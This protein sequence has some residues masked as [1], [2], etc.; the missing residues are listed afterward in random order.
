MNMLTLDYIKT[1]LPTRPDNSHKMT[2]GNV[3]NLAGSINY[4]G[5]AYLSSM[6][7]LR[8]GAGY[9]SLA[10]SPSVC[11]SISAQT[12]NIVTIPLITQTVLISAL[13]ST[14]K[15]MAELE[16]YE[17]TDPEAI[18]VDAVKP[19]LAKLL[20]TGVIAVGSGLSLMGTDDQLH[21]TTAPT[22]NSMTAQQEQEPLPKQGNFTF[23]C[24]LMKA[25]ENTKA[26]LV[27]DADGINFLAKKN[28]L[29]TKEILPS[30]TLPLRSILTPHPKELAR[31]L[32]VDVTM[33][34]RLREHYA[35]LAATTF[36]AVI[37]LKGQH[38]VITDGK[39]TFINPTGNSALAKAG[40]GDVLTGMIA[41]FCAQGL[42]PLEAA[43][44][45]VYLH[46]I[47]GDLAAEQLSA[48]G[49]LASELL[50]YI[51]KA[52]QHVQHGKPD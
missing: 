5:A 28:H 49:L 30:F 31:L 45:S 4:R 44:L 52:I 22:K 17:N 32:A 3:L 51:P 36:N 16:Q 42:A 41:G 7:A 12:P 1:L 33:I 29:K 43:C 18:A 37:V 47:A 25:I 23:F 19:L 26:T 20:H 39:K 46:G 10:S 9:V 15:I 38:T 34:Q 13:T 27:L 35:N 50:E 24:H 11:N 21:V 6:A 14:T 8:V 40:T 48:Y 2:F